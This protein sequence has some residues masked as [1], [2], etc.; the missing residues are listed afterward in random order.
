MCVY[1]FC[2][3]T[4]KC[5]LHRLLHQLVETREHG[6]RIFKM[7]ILRTY[8]T[9]HGFTSRMNIHPRTYLLAYVCNYYFRILN[10]CKSKTFFSEFRA[11]I[12]QTMVMMIGRIQ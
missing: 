7:I 2:F 4:S 9:T 3:L 8:R 6:G 12:S 5:E 10:G 1:L 11:F